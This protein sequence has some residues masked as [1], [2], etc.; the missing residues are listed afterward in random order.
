[1]LTVSGIQTETPLKTN[2]LYIDQLEPPKP[3]IIRTTHRTNLILEI[4]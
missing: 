3:F 4:K 2:Q 1:M